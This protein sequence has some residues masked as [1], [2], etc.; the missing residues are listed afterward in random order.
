[1][2]RWGT[3]RLVDGRC[4]R[5][6]YRH[7]SPL[8]TRMMAPLH[9]LQTMPAACCN[10][11]QSLLTKSPRNSVQSAPLPAWLQSSFLCNSLIAASIKPVAFK[12]QRECDGRAMLLLS[13]KGSVERGFQAQGK[14]LEGLNLPTEG[15]RC[16]QKQQKF[17]LRC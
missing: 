16:R 3:R 8:Y 13:V 9:V 4:V 1:M 14:A 6:A 15:A 7:A 12:P 2:Q 11:P 10:T 5:E 17:G